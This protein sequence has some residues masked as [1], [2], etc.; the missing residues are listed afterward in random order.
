MRCDKACGYRHIGGWRSAMWEYLLSLERVI[1][2]E[3][4]PMLRTERWAWPWSRDTKSVIH[5]LGTERQVRHVVL[6]VLFSRLKHLLGHNHVALHL[7][8]EMWS[9]DLPPLFLILLRF[10]WVLSL[11]QRISNWIKT[12][13]DS[14]HQKDHDAPSPW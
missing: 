14:E 7:C 11:F 3:V 2:E 5:K 1:L 4:V 6:S 12:I 13:R 10:F 9:I 8:R